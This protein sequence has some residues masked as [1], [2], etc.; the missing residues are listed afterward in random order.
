MG[1]RRVTEFLPFLLPIRRKQKIWC[2]YQKLKHDG[3]RYA[4]TQTEDRLPYVQYECTQGLIN[5][6]S[7]YD[8]QY[9]YNKA[10]NLRVVSRRMQQLI[11]RPGEVFSFWKL[12]RGADQHDPYRPGLGLHD[13]KIVPV[14][15]GGL[16]FM[17]E[18]LYWMVLHTPLT[19][20]EKHPHL[21]I[22]LPANPNAEMPAGID[23]TIQEGWSDLKFKNETEMTFQLILDYT[24]DQVHAQFLCSKQPETDYEVSGSALHYFRRKGQ[25]YRRQKIYRTPINRASGRIEETELLYISESRIDYP[26]P[27]STPI[28]EGEPDHEN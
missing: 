21:V 10:H 22:S 8:I 3:H 16:C 27:E 19:V 13:G 9:Q 25:V 4:Q 20:I 17:S 1:R 26:L 24:E 12:A 7:G 5:P 15:G 28:T 6:D 14:H 2:F 18:L 23:A 11:I